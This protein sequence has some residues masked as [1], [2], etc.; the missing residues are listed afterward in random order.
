MIKHLG[1]ILNAFFVEN[2]QRYRQK[3]ERV[4]L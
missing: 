1:E 4:R 2:L 3:G